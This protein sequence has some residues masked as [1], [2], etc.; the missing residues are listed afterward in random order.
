MAAESRYRAHKR[1]KADSDAEKKAA[2]DLEKERLA[3]QHA[4]EEERKKKR[5]G[6]IDLM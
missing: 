1:I 2:D 3:E 4:D 6:I 5:K